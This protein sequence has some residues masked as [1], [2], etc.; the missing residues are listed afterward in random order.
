M[1]LRNDKILVFGGGS[2]IGKA[3]AKR[4]CDA[5]ASVVSMIHTFLHFKEKPL[6][7]NLLLHYPQKKKTQDLTE[8]DCFG[9]NLKWKLIWQ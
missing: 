7:F 4:L 5:G 8:C 3:I 1:K 6:P 2:G 9:K